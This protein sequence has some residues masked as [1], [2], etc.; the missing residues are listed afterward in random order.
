MASSNDSTKAQIEGL[1]TLLVLDDEIKRLAN[2]REFGFFCTNETHRLIPYHTAYLWEKKNILGIEIIA[3]SGTAEF[4]PHTSINLWLKERIDFI[5]AGEFSKQIHLFTIGDFTKDIQETWPDSLPQQ[6]LWCPFSEKSLEPTGGLLFFKE[7]G[8]SEAETKM[9]RWLL[10]S[11]QYT[12]FI[13]LK[14]TTTDRWQQLK[15]KPY[16]TALMIAIVGILFF[17]IHLSVI[18]T[19]TISAKDPAL[20][21]APM[22]GIIK[23][24]SVSP[25][26][27]VK[28]NQ[29]LVILDSSDLLSESKV[30]QRDYSLTEVK[31]R[32]AI[33]QA[34]EDTKKRT[35]IP[36][37]QAQLAVDKAKLDYTQGLLEKTEIRSP[38][39]GIVIFDS[40]EDWIGQ[41]V[42]TGERIL[43]VANPNHL[44]LK[45]ELPVAERITLKVGD[46]G[47]FFMQG[48]LISLPIKITKLGYNAKLMPNKVL[49]YEMEA[50]FLEQ[51]TQLQI[52]AQGTVKL[53][54]NRVPLIY[55]LIRRPL[56][57]FR[58][59]I[60]I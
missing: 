21:N 28:K 18:G 51:N 29:I 53:Y 47:S 22:Q 55:Y 19:G 42:L 39:D 60:G 44:K 4:D 58:Q 34:F 31:L 14:P 6:F 57:S 56:Q 3:Q 30:N 36:I 16:F 50:D 7:G 20:I 10:A 38:I 24:F 54:G 37:L 49:A 2:L 45:I 26:E 32:T 9:L 17:P 13:L 59:T 5:L 52:G 15:K 40:T 46:E 23:S 8:F 1:A 27:H 33:N 12:W 43:S 41:P 48:Q 25:G 11:Y 35:D